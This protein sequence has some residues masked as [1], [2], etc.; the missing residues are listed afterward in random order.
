MRA[1]LYI[2]FEL[3]SRRRWWIG[4]NGAS[5]YPALGRQVTRFAP[6]SGRFRKLYSVRERTVLLLGRSHQ[7]RPNGGVPDIASRRRV[8]RLPGSAGWGAIDCPS[9]GS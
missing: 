8:F 9:G 3:A 5:R 6:I 2:S 7:K 1:I 4:N